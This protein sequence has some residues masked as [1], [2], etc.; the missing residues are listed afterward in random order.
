ML[1]TT[2]KLLEL[3]QKIDKGAI[4][5]LQIRPREF[6]PPE[7][8]FKVDWPNYVHFERLLNYED[9]SHEARPDYILDSLVDEARKKFED[10]GDYKG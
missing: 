2:N 3:A 6:L 5:T 1:R 9:L 4:V 8:V 7:V 10:R